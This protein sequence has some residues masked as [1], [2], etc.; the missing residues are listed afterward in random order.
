MGLGSGWAANGGRMTT[1]GKWGIARDAR[2]SL[3][4][5]YEWPWYWRYPAAF[6]VL[7]GIAWAG[8][9]FGDGLTER[10]G[11][12]LFIAACVVA[13]ACLSV[14]YELGCLLVV[15]VVFWGASKL[16]GAIVPDS[17]QKASRTELVEVRDLARQ[18][19][20]TA[21][22]AKAAFNDGS[23]SGTTMGA[24]IEE[25]KAQAAEAN[26]NA[27]SA[28]AEAARAQAEIVELQGKL[29]AICDR[30]PALCY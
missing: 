19:L 15:I 24:E 10:Q 12:A 14:A 23:A 27:L 16:I 2:G 8:I 29:D 30:A 17:W 20:Y 7:A 1:V 11:W 18:A 28:A 22:E 25:A 6:A 9:Y 21:E 26:A 3:A 13:L 4:S 5:I